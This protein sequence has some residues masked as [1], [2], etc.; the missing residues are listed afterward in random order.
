V[1][2]DER[3]EPPDD[4]SAWHVAPP[5]VPAPP[6]AAAAPAH[7]APDHDDV[8]ARPETP[9]PSAPPTTSPGIPIVGTGSAGP[10]RLDR[11]DRS[12]MRPTLLVAAVIAILLFGAQA[13]NA[14]IPAPEG[15]GV[16]ADGAIELG[17]GVRL[18]PVPGWTV[19]ETDGDG[20][21]LLRRGS[22]ILEVVA[23]RQDGSATELYDAYVEAVVEP[24]AVEL[25]VGRPAPVS[26][27]A[28]FPAIR[29]P[30]IGRCEGVTET[31]E[32]QITVL[33]VGDGIGVIFDAAAVG[34]SLAIVQDDID[35]MID[36]LE[37]GGR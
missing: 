26:L 5:A 28:S 19:L 3:I 32:G 27:A 36:A 10:T 14:A 37:V 8:A 33:S 4:A 6:P 2:P 35:A 34:G 7:G 12:G 22:V 11:L 9:R 1:P 23:A 15:S 30:Y 13:L 20:A 31:V 29:G 25:T 16:G 21:A 17:G 18:Y 24:A